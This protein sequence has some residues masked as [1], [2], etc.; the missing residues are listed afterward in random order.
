M[1]VST[2]AT[3][4]RAE[5]TD[6]NLT[7][8]VV[9]D[10]SERKKIERMKNEFVSVVGHELRTPLTS[11]RGSLGLLAG[12]IAGE[13][14]PEAA[15]MVQLA[16]D[17]TDRLVRLVNDTLELERLDAGRMELDRRPSALG[18]VTATAL[19]AVE[20]LAGAAGV[21]LVNTVGGIRLLADPDRIVQALVNLLGNAVKFSPRGG[22]VTVSA[23]PRGHM[24][25]ISVI[26]QGPG[27]PAEKLDS[28]FERFTQVDSS[29]ARDK[30]GTG[31]G[32][33]ITRAII[34]RHGGPDLGRERR[35]RR[36]DLPDD[37]A[38]ARWPRGDRG[39]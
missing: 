12:G 37:P 18:D 26:D 9:E 2:T 4:Q 10:I 30:G 13:L 31:L 8:A 34:E 20:A 29:D 19:H 38:D 33:A 39:L 32:L 16:V 23:E 3:L 14:P 27:I 36:I 25:L 21:S 1:W 5:E 11:I 35:R 17:N 6:S 7:I 24:A 28:I 15:Q 22:S